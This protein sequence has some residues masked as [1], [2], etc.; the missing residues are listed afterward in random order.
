MADV[1][2]SY[3]SQSRNFAEDVR[4]RL[5]NWGYT[6]WWDQD[7]K[8]GENFV[9]RIRQELE[10]ASAVVVNLS[11]D[12]VQPTDSYVLAEAMYAKLK[13]PIIPV[14]VPPQEA[15]N[16]PPP[17]NT[18]KSLK[19]ADSEAIHIALKSYGLMPT[20]KP[21]PAQVYRQDVF[22]TGQPTY[23]EVDRSRLKEYQDLQANLRMKG[24]IV[25]LWGPTQ[26][27][28]SVLARMAFAGFMPIELEGREIRTIDHFYDSIVIKY[29]PEIARESR[30]LAVNKFLV[31]S[32][33]PIVIDDFHHV[34]TEA[35]SDI[36]DAAKHLI[37]GGVN[38]VLI[39]IPDCAAE[40]LGRRAEFR[41]RSIAIKA[42]RWSAQQ[43]KQIP[44]LGFEWLNVLV[45]PKVID[46]IVCQAHGNPHLVQ[47]FC[48]KLCEHRSVNVLKTFDKSTPIMVTKNVL[49]GIFKDVGAAHDY[50]LQPI[51]KTLADSDG[52]V[53][54]KWGSYQGAPMVS[55]PAVVLIVLDRKGAFTEVR[56]A[57]IANHAQKI[58]RKHERDFITEESIIAAG[59]SF[60][61]ALRAANVP[62]TV[63]GQNADRFF[64]QHADFKVHLHWTLAPR[65]TQIQP[66]LEKLTEDYAPA[67]ILSAYNG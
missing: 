5:M 60:I 14:V 51:L 18:L 22:T 7:I 3:K 48:Y 61:D 67:D 12:A 47:E 19:W 41:N 52:A 49:A 45:H 13:K 26:T 36:I 37:G 53:R 15:Q 58:T 64:I 54:V 32:Q 35:Q 65:L 20:N 8:A 63:I 56:A 44:K 43:L 16:L 38:I 11:V 31:D 28:K 2:L 57:N 17:L 24:R 34:P 46:E 66:Q 50:D 9:G 1:F 39:S 29:A 33:R 6:V 62:D 23:T 21:A 40:I 42:P 27:G 10:N 55:L 25:R 30:S 59:A 4:T